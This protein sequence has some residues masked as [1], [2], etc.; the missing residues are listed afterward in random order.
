MQLLLQVGE[1]VLELAVDV[2]VCV[3]VCVCMYLFHTE[4]WMC[5]AA[6]PVVWWWLR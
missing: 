3:H 6:V 5:K 1:V 4:L 2:C